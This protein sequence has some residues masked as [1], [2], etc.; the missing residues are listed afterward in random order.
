MKVSTTHLNYRNM[1][2]IGDVEYD[3]Y[4][5][6]YVIADLLFRKITNV[7]LELV[8]KHN[9]KLREIAESNNDDYFWQ[10]RVHNELIERWRQPTRGKTL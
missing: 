7:T 6:E 5:I 8:E 3:N 1:V 9:N 10:V 2:K 4:N